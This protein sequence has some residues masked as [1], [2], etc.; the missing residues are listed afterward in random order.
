M[1][2]SVKQIEVYRFVEASGSEPIR[3]TYNVHVRRFQ[4]GALHP[5]LTNALILISN[6]CTHRNLLFRWVRFFYALECY[7]FAL[8]L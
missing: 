5:R 1:R 3:T 4:S 7:L 2:R 6:G 8:V